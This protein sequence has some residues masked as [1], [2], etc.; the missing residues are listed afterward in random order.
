LDWCGFGLDLNPLSGLLLPA[1]PAL[2]QELGPRPFF[3]KKNKRKKEREL[4]TPV[5]TF[6]MHEG[7]L[8]KQLNLNLQEST[9]FRKNSKLQIEH[10]AF[11]LFSPRAG[12]FTSLSF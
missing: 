1:A 6:E 7:M 10:E 11:C 9:R 12:F 4:D 5:G 3:S 2:K 8:L